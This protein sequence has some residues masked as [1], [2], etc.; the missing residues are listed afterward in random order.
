MK[1]IDSEETCGKYRSLVREMMLPDERLGDEFNLDWVRERGWEVVPVERAQHFI[2]EEITTIVSA[3]AQ[4]GYSECVAVA[5]EPLDPLPAC[6]GLSISEDDFREFKKECG[7][8]HYL[9]TDKNRTWAISCT[10][11]YN[12]FAG[13]HELL[14]AM[15][16]KSIKEAWQTYWDFIAQPSMDPNGLLHKSANRYASLLKIR[17]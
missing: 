8:F 5:T 16:G 9:L 4:A 14:E 1:P 15:L 3:L 13:P 17:P 11:A 7:L 10:D 12:L 2:P 6:Y